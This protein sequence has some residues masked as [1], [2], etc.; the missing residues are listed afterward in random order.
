MQLEVIRGDTTAKRVYVHSSSSQLALL[1]RQIRMWV[2]VS[3]AAL[4][5]SDH[6]PAEG[7]WGKDTSLPK[8]IKCTKP[9]PRFRGKSSCASMG[10]GCFKMFMIA[11]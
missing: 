3:L 9:L 10:I 11:P 2:F 4:H 7:Q 8:E 1:C 6:S 5:T